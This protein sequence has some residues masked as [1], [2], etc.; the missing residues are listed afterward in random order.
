[1]R[2]GGLGETAREDP[3]RVGLKK[4]VMKSPIAFDVTF[5]QVAEYE[6]VV[7]GFVGQVFRKRPPAHFSMKHI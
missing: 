6:I 4:G 1:M 7:S 5:C 2:A 3:G